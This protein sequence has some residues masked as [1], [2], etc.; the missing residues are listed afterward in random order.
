M[1]LVH[2]RALR[3]VRLRQGAAFDPAQRA[4]VTAKAALTDSGAQLNDAATAG[5]APSERESSNISACVVATV[6]ACF[7]RP[8][9]RRHACST[10][11]RASCRVATPNLRHY[12][13]G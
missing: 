11:S 8:T 2:R 10:A 13:A 1:I 5:A 9:A 7:Q 6:V 3:Q 12:F 4:N